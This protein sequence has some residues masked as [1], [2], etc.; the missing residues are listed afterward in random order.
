MP[1]SAT[2]FWIELGDPAVGYR[3]AGCSPLH[4]DG[5]H[6]IG[7]NVHRRRTDPRTRRTIQQQPEATAAHLLLPA[8]VLQAPIVEGVH[9][10]VEGAQLKRLAR[11]SRASNINAKSPRRRDARKIER[12]SKLRSIQTTQRSFHTIS[13]RL[14]GS[15]PLRFI[16]SLLR[17]WRCS[18]SS[19]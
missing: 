8:A 10:A 16:S 6:G 11:E 15:A 3:S 13:W 4:F 12:Y 14:C 1:H 5:M 7:G 18:N 2:K 19:H 17:T 9:A